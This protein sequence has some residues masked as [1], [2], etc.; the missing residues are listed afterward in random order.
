MR[1]RVAWLT[2]SILV[3]STG[4]SKKS[5][6]T[7]A[8]PTAVAQSAPAAMTREHA[9]LARVGE[10]REGSTIVLAKLGARTL[11]YVADDDDVSVRAIDI[12]THEELGITPTAGRPSQLLVGK[13]GRLYVAIR[14]EAI[15]Q[16]FDAAKDERAPLDEAS[17]IPT[18]AEP[19]GLAATPDDATLL[20]TSG[21]GHALEAF[22]F[23][24]SA[25]SFAV[26]LGREPRA[27]VAANDGKTAY[28]SHASAGYV[29]VIDL[30]DHAVTTLDVGM[31]GWEQRV[32]LGPRPELMLN[33]AFTDP[34]DAPLVFHCGTGALR[35]IIRF[36]ARVARQGFALA[37]SVDPKSDRLFAPHMQVATGDPTV[38]SMGYGGGG[39][40]AD[41]A[42]MPTELFDIDVVDTTKRTR[43][44][45][46]ASS[47]AVNLRMGAGACRLP[48][49][50]IVDEARH[51]LLVSCL[52]VDKVMEYD[53]SGLTPTGTLKRTFDVAAGPIGLAIAP[54]SR[55]AVVWSAFDRVVSV[56]GLG[57]T[58]PEDKTKAR[59]K[60]KEPA[61][62]ADLTKIQLAAARAPLE[63]S[64]A[65]GRRL[66]HKGGDARIAKDGRA[67]AS[68]HPDGRDDGLVWSTPEGPRQTI[69]LAG[70]V[71]RGAPYG[72]LGQHPSV[73][74]HIKITMKNLAGTGVP[75][76]D[77]DALASYVTAMKAPPQ[78]RATLDKQQERG[79]ELFHS[80]L[81]GCASC[82]AEKTGFT[83]LD[84][85]E[86][87]S[88]TGTD[89]KR[90][91]LAPSLRFVGGSA[92]YFHD[93]R[94][95]TLEEL[96]RKNEKMGD[97]K[98]LSVEDRGALE[99]YL[100]TL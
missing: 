29:S 47:V 82:H 73:K 11:A 42:G 61:P 6:P 100:R 72:W 93:G 64:A 32:Q 90:Q 57:P 91:F 99:A 30:A 10:A 44:T 98:S 4:C 13:D 43:A 58:E 95:A 26:D 27:V 63:E 78:R 55:Q 38:I 97:T 53:A 54:E 85:H 12:A 1:L 46:P 28:V 48:R 5:E 70:R 45:G 15:V 37:K 96:L 80:S 56:I 17:R 40:D 92:P 81:L 89:T 67:C 87:G 74:E 9:P 2:G 79:S 18:A 68:C 20:V 75:D 35:R 7:I 76:G 60:A 33:F 66:F 16:V 14:D 84:V 86:I 19:V 24:S 23:A 69:L 36:P 31:S 94:Y 71:Q 51:T 3:I 8:P 22:A 39:A 65:A 49:A 62:P 83:D 77:F 21:W 41:A 59:T 25:R 88:A 34:G 52:G 50:A